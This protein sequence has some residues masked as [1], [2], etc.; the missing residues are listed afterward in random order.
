MAQAETATML[1]SDQA[2]AEIDRW[3]RKFNEQR[4]GLNLSENSRNFKKTS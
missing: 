2:R 3:L 4:K 1:I